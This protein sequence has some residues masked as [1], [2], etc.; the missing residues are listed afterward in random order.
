MDV[1][2]AEAPGE[3]SAVRLI[4]YELSSETGGAIMRIDEQ[5]FEALVGQRE[6]YDLFAAVRGDACWAHRREVEGSAVPAAAAIHRAD[7][8]PVINLARSGRWLTPSQA[9]SMTAAATIPELVADSVDAEGHRKHFE[10]GRRAVD[11]CVE[12]RGRRG[13]WRSIAAGPKAANGERTYRFAPGEGSVTEGVRGA[14]IGYCVAWTEVE[15]EAVVF[16]PGRDAGQVLPVSDPGRV[17]GQ[18][19]DE[20]L[21]VTVRD[22]VINALTDELVFLVDLRSERSSGLAFF[23]GAKATLL[24]Q[25][26]DGESPYE[27]GRVVLPGFDVS[28]LALGPFGSSTQLLAG[29]ALHFGCLAFDLRSAL[30][31]MRAGPVETARLTVK[32]DTYTELVVEVPVR[33]AGEV[34]EG[35]FRKGPDGWRLVGRWRAE[36]GAGR[37]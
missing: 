4:C 11:V 8:V 17:L 26:L 25:E 19:R 5:R 14:A 2:V 30:P 3:A 22:A 29:Q 36:R 12:V 16:A 20:A 28:R 33:V 1:G 34:P 18:R 35:P 10:K 37:R 15:D 9:C 21:K 13:I 7:L 27:G 6:G 31:S 32:R 23:S 24:G